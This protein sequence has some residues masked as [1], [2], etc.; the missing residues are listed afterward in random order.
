MSSAPLDPL[1]P[2]AQLFRDLRTGRQGLAEREAQRRLVVVGRNELERRAGPGLARE[3]AAQL[4]HP[5]ALLLWA[6]AGLAFAG[7]PPELSVAIVAVILLNAAVGVHPGA[8]RRARGRGAAPL[9]AAAARR[10]CATG[11]R[12]RS[13]RRCWCRA[14]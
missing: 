14:T 12:P 10:W 8:A 4:V 5:L 9:P 11:A 3:V 7:R 1:E 2:L 6:A 13:T